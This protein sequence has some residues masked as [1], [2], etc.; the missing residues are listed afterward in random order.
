MSKDPAILFYTSDFL[1]GTLT[2]SFEQRGKYIV[3]LCLQHQQGHLTDEDMKNICKTYDAKIYS[4]F[5]KAEDGFYYNERM[6]I[7]CEK[8]K[9]Y[10]DSRR[11]NRT[12]KSIKE[13]NICE[14]Y[15][16]HMENENSISLNKGGVGEK[17]INI[18]FDVFWDAYGKKVGNK[19]LCIQRWGKL[20]DE[21][22]QRAIDT[23]P[24]FI[25]S[26]RDRQF[27]PYPEKYLNERRWEDEIS[28]PPIKNNSPM[29]PAYIIPGWQSR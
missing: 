12:S 13:D 5:M 16:K 26:I 23:L 2:M 28:T 8:R 17:E 11:Q 7:E 4:K 29:T 1:T 24:A 21:E 9:K 27:L 14:S 20:K 18:S 25:A 10:S 6:K 19:K 3:L 15:D 22:R